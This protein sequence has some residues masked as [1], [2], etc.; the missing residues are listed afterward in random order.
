MNYNFTHRHVAL[1]V[2]KSRTEIPPALQDL[3]CHFTLADGGCAEKRVERVEVDSSFVA[4]E[5]LRRTFL[6]SHIAGE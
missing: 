5:V 6:V 4:T 2:E 1:C 3:L